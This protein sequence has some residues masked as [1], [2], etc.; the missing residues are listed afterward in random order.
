MN[1]RKYLIAL[2][3]LML[4]LL[5]AACGTQEEPSGDLPE[6][7]IG[8]DDYRP[9]NYLD[10]NGQA[11]GVDVALATEAC[12]RMGY[13]PV[14][15]QISWDEKDLL[16]TGERLPLGRPLPVQRSGGGRPR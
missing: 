7:V 13:E 16:L 1:I 6:L 11:A 9:Y 14:F 15:R 5:P 2:T 10:E 3:V 8:S 4:A 12:R